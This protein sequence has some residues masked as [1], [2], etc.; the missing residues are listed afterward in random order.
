MDGRAAFATSGTCIGCPRLGG[1]ADGRLAEIDHAFL[2]ID[3]KNS[4]AEIVARHDVEGLDAPS[5]N[6][7]IPQPS[8]SERFTA[9]RATAS[10]TS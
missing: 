5:L 6:S 3:V 8:D 2:A 10:R 4:A 1:L 7:K 9:W